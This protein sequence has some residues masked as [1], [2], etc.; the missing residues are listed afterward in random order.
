MSSPSRTA[1][2]QRSE[3]TKERKDYLN[4]NEKESMYILQKKTASVRTC[5]PA[6]ETNF[7]R[8]LLRMRAARFRGLG[9]LGLS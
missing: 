6:P 4:E 9:P 5:V 8:V 2:R 1:E 3:L 7:A